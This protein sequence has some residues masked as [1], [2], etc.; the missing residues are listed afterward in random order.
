MQTDKGRSARERAVSK[1]QRSPKGK[2][3]LRR[4]NQKMQRGVVYAGGE[5]I[6]TMAI[7]S[8][9]YEVAVLMKQ[10]RRLAKGMS[11]EGD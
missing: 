11:K 7:S 6:N 3:A 2:A 4:R 9:F 1:Y 8:E 5:R 10:L